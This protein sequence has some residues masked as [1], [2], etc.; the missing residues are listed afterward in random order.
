MHARLH[1]LVCSPPQYQHHALHAMVLLLY[2]GGQVRC[3]HRA[4]Y[5]FRYHRHLVSGKGKESSTL[6]LKGNKAKPCRLS[7]LHLLR[8]RLGPLP[9]QASHSSSL[10]PES[11]T[12]HSDLPCTF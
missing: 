9:R 2:L 10:W 1:P 12:A 3:R 11:D 8:W 7:K 4:L 5:L 6:E